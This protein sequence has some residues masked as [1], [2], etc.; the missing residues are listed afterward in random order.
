M[1]CGKTES[2]AKGTAQWAEHLLS[3]S[4]QEVQDAIPAWT[5][6]G[7]VM[8]ACHPSNQETG[9]QDYRLKAVFRHSDSEASW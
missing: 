5:E 3:M 7:L 9:Q 2:G 4:L 8:H 6:Q 1:A